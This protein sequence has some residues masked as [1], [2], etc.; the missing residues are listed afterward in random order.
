V[1]CC[2]RYGVGASVSLD[3]LGRRDGVDAF[4]ALFSET[5]A[6]ALVAVTPQNAAALAALAATSGVPAVVLGT[7]GGAD[8]AIDGLFAVPLDELRAAHEATLPAAFGG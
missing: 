4:V 7:T 3:E 6:R 5:A 2:L 8:L 1:E